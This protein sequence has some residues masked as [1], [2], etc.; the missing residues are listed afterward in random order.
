MGRPRKKPEDLRKIATLR[1]CPEVRR[2]LKEAATK[3]GRSFAAD[4]EARLVATCDLDHQGVELVRAIAK[5]VV[6]IEQITRKRWHKDLKTWAVI[7]EML[8]IGPVNDFNPDLPQNDES[9]I[10]AFGMLEILEQD[11]SVLIEQLGSMGIAARH[12]P[13][14][15][16]GG[17]A[18]LTMLPDRTRSKARLMCEKLDDPEER[19]RAANLLEQIIQIDEQYRKVKADFEGA[20]R[21]HLEA[22]KAGRKLYR[23]Y[24]RKEAEVKKSRGKPYDILHIM[25][26]DL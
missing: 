19:A 7:A 13:D 22:T 5:E 12:D 11:R 21:L 24:L 17:E 8:R 18:G 16:A 10:A 26:V 23:D 1:L 20:L 9:V 3:A 2:K 6:Q 4:L 25:D 15:A 14:K